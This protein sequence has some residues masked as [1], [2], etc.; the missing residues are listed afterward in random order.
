MNAR[1]L[2]VVALLV[3]NLLYGANYTIAKEVMPEFMQ[4]F[5][6]ILLRVSVTTVLFHIT[7]A[8]FNWRVPDKKDI[9]RFILCGF[10]GIAANQLMFF[11]GLSMTSRITASLIM[12]TVPVLVLIFSAIFW[13]ERLTRLKL[14]GV[15]L[16]AIGAGGIILGKQAVPG[17]SDVWGNVLV[18][19]NAGSFAAYLV[20]VK[21]LMRKYDPLMV[22][23]WVFTFGL[24][25]VLPFGYDQLTQTSFA[26]MPTGIWL[27]VGYVVLLNTYVAYG[28]NIYAL[29][30][31]NPSVVGI[32]IYLQ[33]V[34]ASVIAIAFA[35]EVLTWQII[36]AAV[37]IF[38][39]V[40]LVNRK[41]AAVKPV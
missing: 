23:T 6:F 20:T 13:K 5:G 41:P 1:W 14:T 12:I 8:F 26:T 15:V 37:L 32:F 36:A 16:G 38:I 34:F 24:A 28:L 17:E 35:G 40:Y 22:I 25:F 27:A 3:V 21:G 2:P 4:P 11:Q 9:P 39:G 33:P 19:L 10:L 29:Q 31:V 7:L 30:K 18:F